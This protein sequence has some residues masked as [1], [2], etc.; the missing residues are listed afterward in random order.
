V[1]SALRERFVFVQET[2]ITVECNPGTL[3]AGRLASYRRA[4][5]NRLSIGLQS[6]DDREL[7]LLGRIHTRAQFEES[8][9]LARE[10]G[11]RNINIDLMSALPGQTASSWESTLR[12]VL[13]LR[14]EHISAYS[15]IIEEGTPF[16]ERYG[17]GGRAE[18]L[19]DEETERA[20]YAR[21]GELLAAAGYEHY[22]I[23]NYALPGFACRH[24][25]GCWERED[26]L[27]FGLGAASLWQGERFSR[28]GSM[29]AYLA[30]AEEGRSTRTERR[31]LTRKDEMEEF[32]FLGLRLLRGVSDAR[33][34]SRFGCGM[35][36]IYGGVIEK[37]E[38][39]GLLAR[40]G[41]RIFLTERGIDVSNVIFSDFLLDE[42]DERT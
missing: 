42:E 29:E 22:E 6:A 36:E 21:T 5:V 20:M 7:K 19:P 33:F 26:Y 8:F 31:R 41:D 39:L 17:D 2:E 37:Y 25:V 16:F 14:P 32:M 34:R 40:D 11:F 15:L 1:L 28:P 23:S 12:Y 27:G 35:A 38:G 13:A 18:L 4:G 9:A 10:A 30:A 3:S 24:N